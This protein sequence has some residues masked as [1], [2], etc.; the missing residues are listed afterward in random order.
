M[1]K[2]AFLMFVLVF[3]NG[4][5]ANTVTPEEK[6]VLNEVYNQNNPIEPFRITVKSEPSGASVYILEN[7]DQA[8]AFIGNTP[9]E[10]SFLPNQN[11]N[12]DKTLTVET[13][14]AKTS[15]GQGKFRAFFEC[16]VVKEGYHPVIIYEETSRVAFEESG[17]D[18][19]IKALSGSSYTHTVTLRVAADRGPG[20]TNQ[21]PE[22]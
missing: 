19:A 18:L 17:R 3:L 9:L 12:Y 16:L 10:L 7:D 20:R 2:L 6:Q 21:L 1:K 4:C 14:D 11:K 5:A 8:G 22:R 15:F 13:K